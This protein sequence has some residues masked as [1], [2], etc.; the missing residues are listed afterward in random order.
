MAGS[1]VNPMRSAHA[2]P[3]CR[4]RAKRTGEPCRAPAVRGWCVC[5]MHGAGGGAAMGPRNGR[6]KTGLYTCEAIEMRR[7]VYALAREA[8]KV[9]EVVG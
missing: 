5:R 7:L 9:E 4:G 1:E 6:F 2:A 3:R 8:R